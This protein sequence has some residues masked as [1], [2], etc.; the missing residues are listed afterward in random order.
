MA[1]P[2]HLVI[3]DWEGTRGDTFGPVLHLIAVEAARLHFG[4]LDEL[5]ARQYVVLGLP[6]ALKKIF[7]HLS[8]YQYEQLLQAVQHALA[9][10]VSDVCLIPGAEKVVRQIQRAGIALAIATNKGQQSLLRT[11]STLGLNDCFSVTR[12]AGQVPAKPC[13][14]MLEE[15]MDEFG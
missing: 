8:L 2:Y 11:L 6:L 14:Q 15:I 12:S 1:K 3:F 13:P 7:P 10:H 9:V 5:Q 4:E